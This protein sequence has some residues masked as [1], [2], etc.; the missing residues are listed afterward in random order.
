MAP[1]VV[2][3]CKVCQVVR[4]P[5]GGM[6]EGGEGEGG[7]GE[8]ERGGGGGE[9]GGGGGGGGGGGRSVVKFGIMCWAN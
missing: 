3:L 4:E 2:I 7:E 8:G 1:P 5:L 6:G 9:R